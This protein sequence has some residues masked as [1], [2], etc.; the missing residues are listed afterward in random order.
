[1]PSTSSAQP[2]TSSRILHTG[3]CHTLNMHDVL[4][5][6]RHKQL[7][8]AGQGPPGKMQP[9]QGG[10]GSCWQ[11]SWV[12]ML[13]CCWLGASMTESMHVFIALWRLS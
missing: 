7:P 13:C 9:P 12:T 6:Q 10:L 4:C 1:M 5:E 3:K 11:M 8:L 2:S